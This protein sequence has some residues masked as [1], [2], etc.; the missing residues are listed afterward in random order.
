MERELKKTIHVGAHVLSACFLWKQLNPGTDLNS[1]PTLAAVVLGGIFSF[2][3]LEYLKM[4]PDTDRIRILP[5]SD[6]PSRDF[7]KEESLMHPP[8]P[9][10]KPE[11]QAPPKT[12]WELFMDDIYSE[13]PLDDL[14]EKWRDR[15]PRRPKKE[16]AHDLHE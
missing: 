5:P 8:R 2:F 4:P 12:D 11:P 3:L 7:W 10:P 13:L 15:V 14:Y 6:A 9:W 1:F 16:V